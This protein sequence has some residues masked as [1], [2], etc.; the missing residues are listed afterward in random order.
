[1]RDRRYAIRFP[2]AADAEI[3][4]MESGARAVGVT[5]D[6]SLGGCFVCTSK[7]FPVATRVRITLTRKGQRIEALAVVRILKPRIGMGIEFI[8][9]EG[10]Y[11]ELLCRWIEQIRQSR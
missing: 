10:A 4:D 2:F 3:I 6:I 8:D 1:M 9:V 11:Q 5:S 7:P